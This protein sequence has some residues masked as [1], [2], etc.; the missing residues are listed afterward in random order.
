M[1]AAGRAASGVFG[2]TLGGP[3][4]IGHVPAGQAAE[5]EQQFADLRGG[6]VPLRIARTPFTKPGYERG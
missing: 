6:R 5:G 4:A 3:V 1:Q 2:P